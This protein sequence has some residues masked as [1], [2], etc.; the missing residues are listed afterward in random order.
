LRLYR[1]IDKVNTAFESTIN[2]GSASGGQ[3]L[4]LLKSR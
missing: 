2:T 3:N 4:A 1:A